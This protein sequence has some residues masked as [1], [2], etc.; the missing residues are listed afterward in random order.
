[1]KRLIYDPHKS[2]KSMN[3]VCFI[4]GS[5]TNYREI[6]ARGPDHHYLVFTNRP[7]CAGIEIARKNK[8]EVLELSHIPYLKEAREKYGTGKVPRNC[9]ERERYEQDMVALIEKKLGRQ[10]DLVCLAG[11]DLWFSD[12]IIDRYFPRILNVHPGD[13][14]RGYAGLHWVPAA[15]AIIAGE[16]VLR[17][18]LFIADKSEDNGPILAQSAPVDIRESLAAAKENDPSGLLDKFN[19]LINFINTEK[20]GSYA[21]FKAMAPAG[22]QVALSN[23]CSSLQDTLKIQGDW[24][25]YPLAVHELIARGRVEIEGRAIFV[26][27]HQMPAHG[28][29]PDENN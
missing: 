1:M 27:G 28:Y 15:K 20:I 17:S 14:T 6:A 22:M 8:H 2:G 25:V 23:V 29:R 11:F 19:G 13:T 10:P 9:A 21:D 24:K 7:G 18:T 4:S 3:I 12:W 16:R 26:D 5:G